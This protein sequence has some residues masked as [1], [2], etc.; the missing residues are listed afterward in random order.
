MAYLYI[1]VRNVPCRRRCLKANSS[2]VR[3]DISVTA[4]KTGGS[5]DEIWY[6][7]PVGM[8][9][10]YTSARKRPLQETSLGR[11]NSSS[12]R[13]DISV[14]A[15]KAGGLEVVIQYQNPVGMAYW[16]RECASGRNVPYRRRC[17]EAN[18]SSVRSDTSV[19]ASKAGG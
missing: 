19:T 2:S 5:E 3:S 16:K 11:A 13:S 6:Q 18:S 12:V 7:N 4:S 15:G 8:A 14:T 17:L 10:L 1:S 9:Y